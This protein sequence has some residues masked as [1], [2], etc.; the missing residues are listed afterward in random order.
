MK[1]LLL[2]TSI[3]TML[4][5]YSYS[6]TP[7]QEFNIRYETSVRGEMK[8]IGN[9][10]VNRQDR[11]NSANVPF[12]DRS[13]KVKMNDELN[14]QYIDIDDNP[15]TFSSSS[16]S[17]SFED[18][19]NA[20]VIY[21]GLYWTATYPYALGVLKGKNYKAKK[22][23]R[24]FADN[25]LIKIPSSEKYLSV[26]GELIFDGIEDS[27]L[28][29]V[30]PYVYYADV[31]QLLT[32]SSMVEGE[33]TVANIRAANGHIAGGVAA[34]WALVLV[35]ESL[36]SSEKKIITYDGFSIINN[37]P[38]T[39]NF[40]G[41]LTPKENAF[42]TKVLG[43]VLEG[44]FSIAG[45]KVMIYNPI[46]EVSLDLETETRSPRNFFNSGIT[47]NNTFV[48]SRNP[49]SK[50]TLGFD[51][52]SFDIPN[53]NQ[54][55]IPNG[56]S[57]LDLTFTRSADQYYLFLTALQIENIRKEMDENQFS[58]TD[59][60]NSNFKYYVV[61]GV[62][63]N[64]H[65]TLKQIEKLKKLGYEAHTIYNEDRNLNY[66]YIEKYDTYRE[67]SLKAEEVKAIANIPDTW[68]LKMEDLSE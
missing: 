54:L 65:N 37:K 20:K 18:K 51:I 10:I 34:G 56:T 3:W 30:A 67:A 35:Y 7:S 40:S 68:V 16:A 27:S 46:T 26:K 29:G 61:V 13:N 66:I 44:D 38:K 59:S 41:F 11:R 63:I 17:F 60:E 25:V 47:E 28:E 49:A 21:A 23:N 36:E 50:N 45:D 8:I 42:H 33:Y 1:Y 39:F 9:N 62:Y 14:M 32:E 2:I 4:S 24:E 43:A 5:V 48:T 31:S 22:S 53:E 15:D 6:Q 58:E 52:F 64:H 19:E 57:S 55:L 12:D